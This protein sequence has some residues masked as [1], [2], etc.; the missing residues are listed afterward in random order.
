MWVPVSA[1]IVRNLK[2]LL[3]IRCKQCKVENKGKNSFH[4]KRNNLVIKLSILCKHLHIFKFF[5]KSVNVLYYNTLYFFEGV[6][7][8]N[9]VL[10]LYSF[11]Y[12]IAQLSVLQDRL[13]YGTIASASI[14][15]GDEYFMS[16]E[17]YGKQ[18]FS[19]TKLVQD[20][21]LLYLYNILI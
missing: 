15:D 2:G 18:G 14:I 7:K 3:S 17:S 6:R 9:V 1:G 10:F 5:A 13:N 20:M 8:L 11:L 21:L 19:S 16:P 4:I 12:G